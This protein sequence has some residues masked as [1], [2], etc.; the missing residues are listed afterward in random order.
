MPDDFDDRLDAAMAR[1]W[2]A[3]A[4]CDRIAAAIAEAMRGGDALDSTSLSKEERARTELFD[5]RQAM[6][7]LLRERRAKRSP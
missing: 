7:I 6:L 4:D 5:A 1:Y 3:L 2:D